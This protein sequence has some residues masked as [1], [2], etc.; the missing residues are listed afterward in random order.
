MRAHRRASRSSVV[1]QLDGPVRS[2]VHGKVS[3]HKIRHRVRINRYSSARR[4]PWE[5]VNAGNLAEVHNQDRVSR[6]RLRPV[7]DR[8]MK[9]AANEKECRGLVVSRLRHNSNSVRN[10]SSK[11]ARLVQWIRN[12]VAGSRKADNEDNRDKRHRQGSNN[13]LA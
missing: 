12:R 9:R 2:K 10:S 3:L 6:S 5:R 4:R 1:S 8:R 7:E 11:G 13:I